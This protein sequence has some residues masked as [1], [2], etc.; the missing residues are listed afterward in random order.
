LVVKGV[1]D[2]FPPVLELLFC[3]KKFQYEKLSFAAEKKKS[4]VENS[5]DHFQAAVTFY[6]RMSD[7]VIK[8]IG[9]ISEPSKPIKRIDRF[10]TTTF[11]RTT[12]TP[13]L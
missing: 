9:R 7:Y 8:E 10:T 3:G 1:R 6:S 12:T 4:F 5:R 2:F 13:V 11:E